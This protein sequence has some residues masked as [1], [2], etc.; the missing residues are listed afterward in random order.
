VAE[1][2]RRGAEHRKNTYIKVISVIYKSNTIVQPQ[3]S[4]ETTDQVDAILEA[5]DIV[6]ISPSEFIIKLLN[7]PQYINHK[8]V[9][10][11]RESG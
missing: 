8:T 5:F 2:C 3:H 9:I 4:M 11:L 6:G 1:H 10:N 7:D